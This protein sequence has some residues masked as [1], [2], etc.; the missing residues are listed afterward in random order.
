MQRFEGANTATQGLGALHRAS[1]FRVIRVQR[2]KPPGFVQFKKP[3]IVTLQE[4]ALTIEMVAM[5]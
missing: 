1:G 4:A 3:G 2:R 5:T